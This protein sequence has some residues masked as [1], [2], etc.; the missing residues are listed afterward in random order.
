MTG[1]AQRFRVAPG[2]TRPARHVTARPRIVWPMLIAAVLCLCAAVATAACGVWLLT[3]AR[4]GDPVR[5]VLRTVAPTQIAAAVMLAAAGVV[6]LSAAP[7]T[8]VLVVTVCVVGALSTVAAGC[9]QSAK[10]VTRSQSAPAPAVNCGGT[11]ATC[12]LSCD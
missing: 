10:V 6:A 7:E 9:W 12:T 8:G 3:R 4:F 5:Q 2:V 1:A 11:C